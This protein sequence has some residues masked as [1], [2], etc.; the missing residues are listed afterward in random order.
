MKE[1]LLSQ[2][3]ILYLIIYKLRPWLKLPLG[4]HKTTKQHIVNL[5]LGLLVSYLSFDINWVIICIEL[6][7]RNLLASKRGR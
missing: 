2:P 6:S 5:Y 3:K 4:E 7:I 1:I